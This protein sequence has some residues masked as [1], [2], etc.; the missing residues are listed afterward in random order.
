MIISFVHKGLEK[1][2]KTKS[3]AGIQANHAVKLR[4]ILGKL[5]AA[6]IIS[7]IDFPGAN[8]HPLKGNKKG[9]WAV[10]VNGN[11]QITFKMEN[12]NVT[13]VDYH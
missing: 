5:N 10:D 7:D 8:L 12:E 13:I 2:F 11:W 1:F 6:K 4:L 9:L 3:T